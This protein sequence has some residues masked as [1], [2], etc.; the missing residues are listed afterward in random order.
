MKYIIEPE[1]FKRNIFVTIKDL[2]SKG[3]KELRISTL[4][5]R[6]VTGSIWF[7]EQAWWLPEL[8]TELLN[9]TLK[10]FLSQAY[11]FKLSTF[12]TYL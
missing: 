3:K 5:P 12:K 6:F 9:F 1:M 11:Y 7:P 2:N 8:K 4:Q 10:I